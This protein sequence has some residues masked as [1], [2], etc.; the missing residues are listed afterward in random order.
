MDIYDMGS[1][2]RDLWESYLGE[3]ILGQ[4]I[5]NKDDDWNLLGVKEKSLEV[6]LRDRLMTDAAL[7]GTRPIKTEHS[8]SLLAYSPPASPVTTNC[9][10]PSPAV[11]VSSNKREIDIEGRIRIAT[12]MDDMEEECF[13]AISMKK[14]SSH[15]RT[16]PSTLSE[17]TH[18]ILEAVE[19]YMEIKEESAQST[20]NTNDEIEIDV[21]I[22]DKNFIE[23]I[24]PNRLHLNLKVKEQSL[25][26][27]EADDEDYED[28]VLD[29][30]H[31]SQ[32]INS[33]SSCNDDTQTSSQSLPP[34]PPSSNNSDSESGSNGGVSASCSPIRRADNNNI[35][36]VQNIRGI[37]GPR[38]YV[39]NGHTTR[40]PI[41]TSLISCQPGST[42]TLILTEEEKRTLIAEGY[43]VPTKLPLTKQEE[44]SLKKVRRKIKNKISAQESRRKKKEYMDGLE[45]KVS[46]LSN[47]NINY[48]SRVNTLE[49]TNRELMKELE[50]LQALVARQKS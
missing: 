20:E 45:R 46:L 37:Y 38:L 47:E 21:D 30:Y 13:P 7:G 43:P 48:R 2:L 32:L 33:N 11:N 16:S 42:G 24:A 34:T 41:H 6:V 26:D 5:L 3:P 29:E 19:E 15:G 39:T 23:M 27:S 17:V 25:S 50:R 31:V 4:D 14:A 36:T 9:P 28:A 35:C 49:Q 8:Y 40:Q 12:K 22:D 10:S 1:D 18:D 44:K